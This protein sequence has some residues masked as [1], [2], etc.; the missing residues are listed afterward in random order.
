[1]TSATITPLPAKLD[2]RNRALRTFVQG[3]SADVAIALLPAIYAAVSGWDGA[4]TSAYWTVVGIS[5][6]KTVTIAAVSYFMRLR[7]TPPGNPA[8]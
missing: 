8:T 6:L 2:A 7:Y 5:L 4:F 1:M 3:L